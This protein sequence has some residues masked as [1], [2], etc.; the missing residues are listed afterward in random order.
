[1]TYLALGGHRWLIAG[2]FRSYELLPLGAAAATAGVQA[3]GIRLV[4]EMFSTIIMVGAPP[5]AALFITDL[6][7]C[8]SSRVVPQLNAFAVLF[9]ARII[10]GLGAVT[11]SLP[12]IS[13]FLAD[14]IVQIAG[15]VTALSRAMM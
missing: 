15:A 4:G 3:E 2:M 5:V 6:A 11:L 13:G 8:F 14:H 7:L 9:P 12:L 1:V 10:V